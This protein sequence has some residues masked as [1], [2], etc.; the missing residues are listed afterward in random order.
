MTEKEWI[1]MSSKARDIKDKLM[2]KLHSRE[3][4]ANLLSE[5]KHLRSSKAPTWLRTLFSA[6]RGANVFPDSPMLGT[7]LGGLS[8]KGGVVD[9]A[10]LKN[11][12]KQKKLEESL[13]G[14]LSA[15]GAGMG[16]LGSYGLAHAVAP[17]H[18]SANA[19]MDAT[20][21]IGGGMALGLLGAGKAGRSLG[22][23]INFIRDPKTFRARNSLNEALS[24]LTKTSSLSRVAKGAIA[25]P[26][27]ALALGPALSK[28]GLTDDILALTAKYNLGDYITNSPIKY[29]PMK[30]LD[31]VGMIGANKFT[32]GRSLLP[33]VVAASGLGAGT[34]KLTE[35][36][37]KGAKKGGDI[38][39]VTQ[40]PMSLMGKF[41]ASS[42]QQK[43]LIAAALFPWTLAAGAG[44]YALRDSDS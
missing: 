38:A 14:G 26:I 4:K 11:I 6:Q 8:T 36:L 2:A 34:G 37:A 3:K 15:V 27:A 16:G 25:A 5:L 28:M 9:T 12:A 13:A 23:G 17:G 44:A 18:F 30:L 22:K 33:G 40:A 31:S 43:A 10:L 29:G 7:I 35:L 32:Y 19:I 41:K 21:I 39:K 24:S 20:P 1:F 42:P